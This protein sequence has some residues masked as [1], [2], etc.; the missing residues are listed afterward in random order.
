MGG[1]DPRDIAIRQATNDLKDGGTNLLDLLADER[2]RVLENST[3][4]KR[5]DRYPFPPLPPT[6]G[7]RVVRKNGGR[8]TTNT[9]D[10][11]IAF[12]ETAFETEWK[13]GDLSKLSAL[14]NHCV[15]AHVTR[16]RDL[17]DTLEL[18]E[19]VKL[20]RE[21]LSNI[22]VS[23]DHVACIPYLASSTTS[24]SH[25][26]TDDDTTTTSDEELECDAVDMAVRWTLVGTH[27]GYSNVLG[28]ASGA[29]VYILGGT[30]WRIVRGGSRQ[31]YRIRDEWTV[32]DEIALMRQVETHR[33]LT[34]GAGATSE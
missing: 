9:T 3:S 30:H 10:R 2:N 22:A 24:S 26:D 4:N 20:Y 17:Y 1:Y 23:I 13:D 14:Y 5:K 12:A 32:F 25:S 29:P 19:Y 27:T 31:Q 7:R 33:L 34:T 6:V 16:G 11:S 8:N 15:S 18:T 28:E 21:G